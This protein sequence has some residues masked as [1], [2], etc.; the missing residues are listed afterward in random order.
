MV[1][2][3]TQRAGFGNLRPQ[4]RPIDIYRRQDTRQLDNFI[5]WA[6]DRLKATQGLIDSGFGAYQSYR[7]SKAKEVALKAQADAVKNKN[8]PNYDG[9]PEYKNWKVYDVE[10]NNT[11]NLL[12]A[13]KEGKLLN[14]DPNLIPQVFEDTRNANSYIGKGVWAN[15]KTGVTT[16]TLEKDKDTNKYSAEQV[17]KQTIDNRVSK[18]IEQNPDI[19]VVEL[20]RYVESVED[21]FFAEFRKR[22]MQD[23][24]ATYRDVVQAVTLDSDRIQG[25]VFNADPNKFNAKFYEHIGDMSDYGVNKLGLPRDVAVAEALKYIIEDAYMYDNVNSEGGR[26]ITEKEKLRIEQIIGALSGNVTD[27]R[28]LR[29]GGKLIQDGDIEKGTGYKRFALKAINDLDKMLFNSENALD[30]EEKDRATRQKNTALAEISLNIANPD[31]TKKNDQG[32]EERVGI[33]TKAEFQKAIETIADMEFNN[34]LLFPYYEVTQ[35]FKSFNA[36]G[37][38]GNVDKFN[39]ALLDI[40]KGD[41]EFSEIFGPNGANY[42][43]NKYKGINKE[44]NS[45]LLQKA[46]SVSSDKEAIKFYTKVFD[47]HIGEKLIGNPAMYEQ[48]YKF[49]Y[50]LRKAR[51]DL[52]AQW[53]V[54]AREYERLNPRA[55]AEQKDAFYRGLIKEFA[56]DFDFIKQKYFE[57][58]LSQ[59]VIDVENLD[60]LPSQF[61]QLNPKTQ[62]PE[63]LY[64]SYLY[65]KNADAWRKVHENDELAKEYPNFYR[66]AKKRAEERYNN[67]SSLDKEEVL[68]EEIEKD[69]R[70][71]QAEVLK[72]NEM[73][74]KHPKSY[75]IW[76]QNLFRKLNIGA[77]NNFFNFMDSTI[78]ILTN[79][80]SLV[81]DVEGQSIYDFMQPP[82]G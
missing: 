17:F 66:N 48:Q 25:E 37:G 67:D 23:K 28:V 12:T 1:E 33:R 18:I 50:D 51:A 71:L 4:A 27:K 19:D 81:F 57:S 34:Y 24:I 75:E 36:S 52:Y 78:Q 26:I 68:A 42:F 56:D 15:N 49:S 47:D 40:D 80:F 45:K 65:A 72:P 21:K 38:V 35:R 5:D 10:L 64:F 58:D 76:E 79:P 3:V 14:D 44:E 74:E 20:N 77:T 22:D 70:I 32:V 59:T 13:Q 16:S 30:K 60:T 63:F 55:S 39:Q 6:N 62:I 69:F 9:D 41:V 7:E 43:I 54:K 46:L 61:L 53:S 11:Q 2:R 73:Q 82:Q 29:S 8:N 31:R